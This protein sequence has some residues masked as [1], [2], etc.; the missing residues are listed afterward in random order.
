MTTLAPGAPPPRSF[1]VL[2][3]NSVLTGGGTDE[4]CVR[5]VQ[6][7]RAMG[8]AVWL[9]GPGGSRFDPALAEAGLFCAPALRNS[10]PR[11]IWHVARCIG[12]QRPQIVHA[13]HGRD[14]W[15]TILAVWLSAPV[16]IVLSRHLAKSRVPG[17]AVNSCF[18]VATP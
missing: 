10:K 7:L 8:Q 1:R 13:H 9:A 16:K 14:Y 12:R 6:V 5:L 18:P 2:Q 3:V 15:P 17:P 11:F 4:S